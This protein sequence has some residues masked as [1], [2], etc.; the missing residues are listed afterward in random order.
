[1]CRSFLL[2]I[3][4]WEEPNSSK[5][6]YG[7]TNITAQKIYTYGQKEPNDIE[8]FSIFT[9]TLLLNTLA[10]SNNINI[11]NNIFISIFQSMGSVFLGGIL[12]LFGNLIRQ[13]WSLLRLLHL[14]NSSSVI[15]PVNLN[16]YLISSTRKKC[17]NP[18]SYK[19]YCGISTV[20]HRSFNVENHRT[21]KQGH[22][23]RC[24]P[25]LFCIFFL[26]GCD[27]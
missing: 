9:I 12:G 3:G 17:R 14:M 20:F 26:Y 18:V 8:T 11:L 10:R 4:S 24:I 16:F 1:M 22:L 25:K 27:L 6:I 5:W 2:K 21:V 23:S 7:T 19:T 15:L 13:M